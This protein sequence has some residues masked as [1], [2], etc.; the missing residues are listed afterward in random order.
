MG[1]GNTLRQRALIVFL[2]YLAFVVY[3][4]LVPL[5]LRPMTWDEAI[6]RFLNI[7][8]LDLGVGSRAD[9]IA[10][11]VLYVPLAF[12]GCLA[13]LGMRPAPWKVLPG[14]LLV[15]VFCGAV[16]VSVEFAQL[17]FAPR[18]VSLNDLIAEGIG[19]VVGVSL[20]LLGRQRLAQLGTDF[21]AGGRQSVLA[22]MTL[23]A[24]IYLAF[25]LF[26]FDF[27]ISAQE[28]AW[29]L[30]SSNVGWLVAPSCGDAVRCTA[31]MGLDVAA[32][33]PFGL[34]AA[35]L[36]PRAGYGRLFL[37]GVA[38]GLLIEPLQLL[39]ASGVSQGLSVPLRGVGFVV[40]GLLGHWFLQRG[41]RTGAQAV[42]VAGA[43]LALPYLAGLALVTGWFST[44]AVGA[45]E[46]LVRLEQVR[47]LP[48][49]YH[50]YTSEAVAMASTLAHLALY[51]P[52]GVFTWAL[53]AA[54]GRPHSGAGAALAAFSAVA[55][56]ALI[57]GGKLFFPP[58]HPDPTN[59]LIAAVGAL[60][61]LAAARWF[62]GVVR[63]GRDPLA[64]RGGRPGHAIPSMVRQ[65]HH[66]RNQR[67]PFVLSLSKDANA[68]PVRPEPVEGPSPRAAPLRPQPPAGCAP[69]SWPPP[70]SAGFIIGGLF[71]ILAA[72]GIW[73]FPVAPFLLLAAL[74]LYGA[75]LWR[76]PIAWIAV[77]PAALALL[78]PSPITGRLP[79]DAFDLVVLVT[80]AV[81][82]VRLLGVSPTP[83]PNRWFPVA[84]V[85][86]W[87]SWA[88][89]TARGLWPLGDLSW[90]L[91]DQS[92]SPLEA[93]MVGKGLLWTLLLVPLLRRVPAPL[94]PHAR[95]LFAAGVLVALAG[96]AVSVLWE[97]HLFVGITDFSGVFRVTG[98]FASMHTGGA[99]IEAFLA[100]AIPFAA[101]GAFIARNGW[102]RLGAILLV[103]LGTYAMMVTFSRGGWFGLAVGLT[104]VVVGLL[105]GSGGPR[106]WAVAG[107][108]AAVV[109]AAALPVLMGGFAQ[110]RI[111]LIMGD[112][113]FR[114]SHWAN[115]LSI[116][117]PGLP[118]ALFGEG[119]GRYPTVYLL[120]SDY[121]QPPGNFAI[122]SEVR[123]AWDGES[124]GGAGVTPSMV[125]QA[126]HERSHP[127][128]PFVP[129]L[130][131][132]A[133]AAP[134]PLVR[135]L[136][137]DANADPALFG[138]NVSEDI[139][140]TPAP[141]LLSLSKD[142]NATSGPPEPHPVRP[143]PVEGPTP[144]AFEPTT[145]PTPVRPEPVEGPTRRFL[146]LGTGEP[147]YLDQRV[148]VQPEQPYRLSLRIRQET[149]GGRLR[150]A[151]CEKALLYSFQCLWL[152]PEPPRA[153]AGWS[154]TTIDFDSGALGRGGNWPHPPVVLSLYN[155]GRGAIE[156][157]Q[158]S[159]T[160][161]DG[162]ELLANGD[163]SAGSRRWLFVTDRFPAWHIDQLW[164]E[165][166]FAQGLLGLGAI[167]VLLVAAGVALRKAL[168]SGE[169]W[170]LA[171]AAALLG[172]LAVGLLGSTLDAAR[173]SMLLY[174]G[175]L[176]TAFASAPALAEAVNK[177]ISFEPKPSEHSSH[178]KHRAS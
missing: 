137:K 89:A 49:F 53:W 119:F 152:D 102:L 24:L 83:W 31:R 76:Y 11:G 73:T 158:V 47:W 33:L 175:L 165:A 6:E 66:E 71:A 29:K 156:V 68:T 161:L 80:L 173:I 50:Y 103:A 42:V 106:R 153:G 155:A 110:A 86:L 48:F 123:E 12:L 149:Q 28:L 148:A 45:G 131:K 59:L 62:E 143:E 104:V 74:A 120:R 85:L 10:N 146:R 81:G 55:V 15:L 3:G 139:Q 40:G 51:A 16:A 44:A 157:D 91:P 78:D 2:L 5:E 26:P 94:M 18:T 56:A 130:W 167:I 38:V 8:Y 25:S 58:K 121:R 99:Y 39:L 135:N 57:E 127:H 171:L 160:T 9:W 75:L 93:W 100:F 105:R 101:V 22:V 17:W 23:Y 67:P 35:L 142:A 112:W 95:R 46:A 77:I 150:V 178:A 176:A 1:E 122:L 172:F 97:R 109:L 147:A 19:S 118:T 4:S 79:L 140:A 61:A 43:V 14:V 72:I 64:W 54:R 69:A 169:R 30:Q 117:E 128:H 115:A 114:L 65:A 163:F 113:E 116:M 138:Q 145:A 60:L 63:A 168:R 133:N 125:R 27:L 7:P 151:L 82:Y 32:A 13:L 84:L 41:L 36:W 107:G 88:I 154:E 134:A 37:A 162:R 34:L 87:I 126:H 52:L 136:W 174:L 20:W 111:A 166:Y 170:A 96:V 132:D 21:L 70:A 92:H 144:V 177:S 90:P 108:L 129:H 98:P 141:F 164:V 124:R 159:L